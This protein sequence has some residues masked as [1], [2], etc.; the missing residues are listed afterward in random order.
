MHCNASAISSGCCSTSPTRSWPITIFPS[1][2]ERSLDDSPSGVVFKTGTPKVFSLTDL[3]ALPQSERIRERGI[4]SACSVPLTSRQGVLGTLDLGSFA[5]DAISPDQ[6]ELLTRVAG[7]IAI[8][9]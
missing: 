8:A 9:V 1:C 6:L 5:H 2:S 7:Q 3:E 4:R